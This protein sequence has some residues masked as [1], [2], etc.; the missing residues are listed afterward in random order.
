MMRNVMRIGLAA[1]LSLGL[2]PVLA[3]QQR[4]GAGR[5]TMQGRGSCPGG[6]PDMTRVTT[7]VGSMESLSGG[8]GEG[9]PTVSLS[10]ATGTI[11]V[12]ASPYRALQNGGLTL[13]EGMRLEVVAAP[14][15]VD[16]V[17][18][19]VA[20]T[21]TD[22]ATGQVVTLRDAETGYPLGGRRGRGH[23]FQG[24]GRMQP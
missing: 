7:Y 12:L 13:K 4:G 24:C 22:P 18:H 9:M 15:V 14:V 11:A 16:G 17:E 20:L 19:W 5:G 23:G 2:A 8:R 1:A 21:I 6:G 3:A 10:T